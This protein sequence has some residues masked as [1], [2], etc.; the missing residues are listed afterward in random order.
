MN[1]IIS[2]I[3]PAYNV[4]K[5][6]EACIHS[7]ENQDLPRDSYEIIIVN[8]GSTDSTYS[9]IERLSGVYENIRIVTQKNQGLSVARNNGFKLARGKYV[10]FID[11]DDRI[12][13]NCLGKCLE[14]MERDDLDALAVAPSVPFREIFPYKFDSEAD[15]SKVYDGESF[16]LDSG[17]FVVGAWCYIFK[18]QFWHN[19][20]FEFY[21][22]ISYEDTQ[23]I[24]WAIAHC[25][26]IAGL[27]KF[28]CYDY[29]QRNGSIMNTPVNQHK[30][31]S[32]AMIVNS[33]L[34]Y[35]AQISSERLKN[36]FLE[37][38]TRQYISGIK[39][40]VQSERGDVNV[41][42]NCIRKYPTKV[43][44]FPYSLYQL[45]VLKYPLIFA[46]LLRLLK[47]YDS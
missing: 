14:I 17:F 1:P 3:A 47:K 9:T 26:R 36:Y 12:S 41:F 21:P 15:V 10:W 19:N 39:M 13:S 31:K 43:G 20:N 42:L 7:C 6:I 45:F 44:K 23:L 35:S 22:G 34:D 11:S 5:Y 46:K 16:L 38:S 40:S 18:R 4:E 37:N 33:H 2:L 25:M 30:I 32:I 27:T 24:P 29:I 28:S 8:D